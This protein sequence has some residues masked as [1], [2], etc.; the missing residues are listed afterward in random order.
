MTDI[1][2]EFV[3]FSFDRIHRGFEHYSADAIMHRVRWE[4][5]AHDGSEFK[6]NNNTVADY[7]RRFHRAYPKYDGFFRTRRSRYDE[8]AP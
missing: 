6:V 5:N 3:R 7:A 2:R 8:A 4:T 1:W